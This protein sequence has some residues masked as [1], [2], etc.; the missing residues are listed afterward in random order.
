MPPGESCLITIKNTLSEGEPG[1]KMFGFWKIW[2]EDL[3]LQFFTLTDLNTQEDD[4]LTKIG[5]PGAVK[6][7]NRGETTYLFVVNPLKLES[8]SFRL[9]YGSAMDSI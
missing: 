5:Q 8:R 7:L 3:D 4:A 6:T 1:V 9:N 2:K